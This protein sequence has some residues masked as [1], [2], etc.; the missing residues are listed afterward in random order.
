MK[1]QVD[2]PTASPMPGNYAVTQFVTLGCPTPGAAIYYT[3]DGSLP[4]LAS[5]ISPNSLLFSPNKVIPIQ[6]RR[7]D[8]TGLVSH[9]TIR[10]VAVKDGLLP[11]EVIS[12]Q[13]TITARDLDVYS[14][15]EIR[16]GVFMIRDC[17]DDKLYLVTGSQRALLIDTGVGR[18]DLRGFA[19]SLA[20]HHPLDLIITHAHPDHVACMGQFQEDLQ[21]Y[22][23]PADEPLLK[24]MQTTYQLDLNPS[25]YTAVREG[26]VFDLGGRSLT[27]YEVPGHTPGSIVL[28]DAANGMLFA[29]DAFGSNRP[30][31]ADS[32]WMQ[33]NGMGPVDEYLSTLQGFRL[34]LRGKIKEIFTGH[35]DLPNGE[36]YLDSV[37]RAA[38]RFVDR[39]SAVLVPSLRPPD[40]W[41]V[42]EGDRLSDPN[43]AAI[44]VRSE[45]SLSTAPD[46]IATLSCIELNGG[47]LCEKFSPSRL[48]YTVQLPTQATWVEIIPTPTSSR[49][50]RVRVNG[51]DTPPG[52]PCQVPCG[53][54]IDQVKISVTAPNGR[55]TRTYTLNFLYG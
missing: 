26:A 36:A 47:V 29:G 33:L 23:H 42:I 10:A 44:N 45:G 32:L 43:W 18:G 46:K 4:I 25:R 30:H 54:G 16:P 48:T 34:K 11:S 40:A 5:A 1:N 51:I 38:Q 55:T 52:L 17:S 24:T 49:A 28:A 35:N 8:N 3:L 21:V 7:K 6:A 20:P 9:Y 41:Q 13:Y 53:D 22:M 14:A 39:G 27:V 15:A 50:R 31:N 2:N 37:Q 19:E 12:F